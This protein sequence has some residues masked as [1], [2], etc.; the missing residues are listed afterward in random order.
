MADQWTSTEAVPIYTV[1]EAWP[2]TDALDGTPATVE[3]LSTQAAAGVVSAVGERDAERRTAE[4][5]W[6]SSRGQETS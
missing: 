1:D 6:S 4:A 2:T 5:S 3:Q